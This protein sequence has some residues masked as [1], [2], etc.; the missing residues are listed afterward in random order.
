MV[1]RHPK[2]PD[3][4]DSNYAW[5]RSQTRRL[6]V[7]NVHDEGIRYRIQAVD[8]VRLLRF[9][10]RPDRP[11]LFLNLGSPR[12]RGLAANPGTSGAPGHVNSDR[13]ARH[14]HNILVGNGGVRIRAEKNAEK[15]AGN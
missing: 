1:E 14:F 8:N 10:L 13:F 2:P 4:I 9:E 11:L 3:G 5:N 6:S 7:G 12:K 15:R